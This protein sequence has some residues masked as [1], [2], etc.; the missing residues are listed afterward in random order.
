MYLLVPFYLRYTDEKTIV[1]FAKI[2]LFTY[3]NSKVVLIIFGTLN[4]MSCF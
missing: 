4:K 3:D 1:S 2:A